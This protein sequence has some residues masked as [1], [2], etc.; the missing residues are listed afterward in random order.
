[1]N[2]KLFWLLTAILL[3]S[4]RQA[5]PQ[6]PVKIPRIGYLVSGSPSS[7]QTNVDSF[8]QGLRDL[9]YVE[10]K[11]IVIEYRY[12]GGKDDRLRDLAADLVHLK[13]DVIVTSSTVGVRAAKQLTGTIP[14]VMTSSGDP[15]ARA[16]SPASPSRV[17]TLLDA[18][19]LAQS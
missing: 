18:R 10:G 5:E 8:R 13:V 1:M 16:S 12:A 17:E 9:G 15:V 4:T 14:I 2:P 11:N 19:P 7:G 6:Q 3:V